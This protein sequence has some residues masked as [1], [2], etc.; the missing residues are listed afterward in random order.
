MDRIFY[1]LKRAY[2]STLRI[3]RRDFEEIEMTPARM[4][5]LHVLYNRGRKRKPPIWQSTL[6]RIIGYTA[7]STMSEIMQALE[8]LHLVRRTRNQQDERQLDVELTDLGFW[9]LDRAN[10]CFCPGW[11][12]EALRWA[13]DWTPPDVDTKEAQAW[14]AHVSKT[15]R[16]D[17]LLRNIRVAL[18]DTGCVRYLRFAQ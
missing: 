3:T 18:R 12:Q 4:D 9:A 13:K 15:G 14:E 16:L 8:R 2:H 10:V 6:R 11:T 5:I 7:R 1:A 17:K